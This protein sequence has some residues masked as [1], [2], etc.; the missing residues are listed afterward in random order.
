MVV[1]DFEKEQ[2][3]APSPSSCTGIPSYTTKGFQIY[4]WDVMPFILTAPPTDSQCNRLEGL[5]TPSRLILILNVED[6]VPSTE[7]TR[8]HIGTRAPRPGQKLIMAL[9]YSYP[10]QTTRYQNARSFRYRDPGMSFG[11]LHSIP[12][13]SSAFVSESRASFY[14]NGQMQSRFLPDQLIGR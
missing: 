7:A 3:V 13:A 9:E 5:W 2:H 6:T 8:Q 10:L 12:R 11:T 1:S 14:I 4:T